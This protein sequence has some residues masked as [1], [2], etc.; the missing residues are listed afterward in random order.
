VFSRT[1]PKSEADDRDEGPDAPPADAGT[2]AGQDADAEGRGDQP[3]PEAR[4]PR[5]RRKRPPTGGKKTPRKWVIPDTINRRA[6][7]LA[8]ERGTSVSEVVSEILDR[9]LP[10]WDLKRV[11]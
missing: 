10:I 2:D 6:E 1:A 8:L 7:L 5:T 9:N 4:A 3:G 11:G